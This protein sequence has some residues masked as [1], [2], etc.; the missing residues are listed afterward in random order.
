MIASCSHADV[1]DAARLEAAEKLRQRL[2]ASRR[3]TESALVVVRRLEG[4]L[5]AVQEEMAPVSRTTRARE[6]SLIHI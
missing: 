5:S 6:L 2:R 4:Q 3:A 1:D